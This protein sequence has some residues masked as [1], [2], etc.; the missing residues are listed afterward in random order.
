MK[1]IAVF[2]LAD[3]GDYTMLVR[4]HQDVVAPEGSTAAAPA[5]PTH[6][7]AVDRILTGQRGHAP[8]HHFKTGNRRHVPPCSTDMQLELSLT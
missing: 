7:K 1:I 4:L 2:F 3:L 8:L 5:D 6:P